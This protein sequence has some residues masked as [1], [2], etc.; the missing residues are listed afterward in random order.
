MDLWEAGTIGD[1]A[2]AQKSCSVRPNFDFF[3]PPCLT[4]L[5]K[6]SSPHGETSPRTDCL[7]PPLLGGDG[8]SGIDKVVLWGW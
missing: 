3:F 5:F 4:F 6:H 7:T 2:A 1:L 8:L